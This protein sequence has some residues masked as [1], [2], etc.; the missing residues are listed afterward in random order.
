MSEEQYYVVLAVVACLAT[1]GYV[2]GYRFN[3]L[4]NHML[5]YEW[6]LIGLSATCVFIDKAGVSETAGHIW[7]FLDA[8]SRLLGVTLIGGLGIMKVTHDL[9]LS[10]KSEV[11][12]FISSLGVSYLF[13]HWAVLQPFLPFAYLVTGA[14]FMVLLAYVAWAAF[15]ARLYFHGWAMVAVIGFNFFVALLQDFIKLPTEETSIIFNQVVIEHVVWSSSFAELFYVYYALWRAKTG[16]G[17]E[18]RVMRPA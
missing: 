16:Q 8:F 18:V 1:V 14:L 11:L 13:L 7:H 3:Q 9:E 2:Y 10:I 15:R 4:K 5:G 17:T 6:Y 12:I